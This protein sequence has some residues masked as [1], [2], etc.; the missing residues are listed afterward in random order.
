MFKC[1]VSAKK[2]LP[3]IRKELAIAMKGTGMRTGE[4][5]KVL[6][7]TPAAVSQY[8]SGKRGHLVLVEKELK[9]I[10]KMVK[11]SKVDHETVC[12]LCKEVTNRIRV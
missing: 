7:T 4:I 3:I 1:E 12:S 5:A 9:K 8:L 11:T 6:E 2:V 10:H